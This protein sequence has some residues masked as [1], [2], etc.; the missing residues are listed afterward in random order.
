LS[1]PAFSAL[2]FNVVLISQQRYQNSI[3][4]LIVSLVYFQSLDVRS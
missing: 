1:Y 4:Y 3:I 2:R